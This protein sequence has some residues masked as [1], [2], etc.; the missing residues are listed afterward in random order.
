MRNKIIKLIASIGMPIIA[1]A[2]GSAFTF[3]GIDSW[4]SGINKPSF[5]PPNW[6]FGPVWTALYL[7][8]GISAWLVLRKYGEDQQVKTALFVFGIQLILNGLWSPF[9]F[10]FKSTLSG[11]II[12]VALIIMIIKTMIVFMKIS[13]TAAFLLLPYILWVSFASILNFFLW[14]LNT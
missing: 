7:I 1:G 11:M 4:Y 2:I 5:N 14:K 9:F 10:G 8:M 12:I 3:T 6:I 13:K